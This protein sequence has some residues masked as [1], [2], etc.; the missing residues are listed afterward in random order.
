MTIQ[1]VK[2]AVAQMCSAPDKAENLKVMQALIAEAAF[3]GSQIIAFPENS[4]FFGEGSH[5][6]LQS[7]ETE[8]GPTLTQLKAWAKDHSIWLHI[9]S[10]ALKTTSKNKVTNSSFLI[11][12]SGKTVLRYDKIHLF[13]VEVEGDRP[14]L[15]SQTIQAGKR[16]A[17]KK[18]PLGHLGL[19]ICY[20]LRFPELYRHLSQKGAQILF[21]PSAFTAKT[22]AA[23]WDVLTR[24]RAIENQ[25]YL[26]APAQSGFH[27][28]G[29]ETWG[30]SR[31]LSPW[32]EVLAEKKTGTGLIYADLD[33][34]RLTHLRKSF[35]VLKH[36][37]SYLR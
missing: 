27:P 7:A 5:A 33:L 19:S 26:I 13:D 6:L 37:R 18:T 15:E 8:K 1:I 11:S 34:S 9:G 12:P 32:G 31:I 21:A 30:H 23:H 3:L 14:Y 24:A 4:T 29:R 17:H 36:R 10:L 35:P 20:D 25:T 28:N 2:M 16:I 22:G